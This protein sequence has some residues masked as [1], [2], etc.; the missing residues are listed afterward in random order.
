MFS[1][2]GNEKY[3]SRFRL[4]AV[5]WFA[6]GWSSNPFTLI[7]AIQSPTFTVANGIYLSQ[8]VELV[9]TSDYCLFSFIFSYCLVR[10]AV[11]VNLHSYLS[12]ILF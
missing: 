6:T 12:V 8:V 3:F 11:R 5:S 7:L 1:F 9:V 2:A 4:Y 10:A